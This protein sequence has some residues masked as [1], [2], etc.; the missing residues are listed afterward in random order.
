MRVNISEEVQK[1]TFLGDLLLCSLSQTILNSIERDAANNL[2]ADINLLVNGTEVDL[3]KFM[4]SWE[5]SFESAIK[6][7]ARKLLQEQYAC[8]VEEV[9]ALCH[10]VEQKI[11]ALIDKHKIGE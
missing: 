8:M 10:T 11:A 1:N 2:T 3:Q 6:N 9:E 4:K 7:E 5:E